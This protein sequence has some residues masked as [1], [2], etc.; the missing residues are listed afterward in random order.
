MKEF[1]SILS[2]EESLLEIEKSKFITHTCPVETENEALNFINEIK[3]RHYNATHNVSAFYIRDNYFYKKYSDDGEPG[4]TAGLPSLQAILNKNV[5]DVC[6]V[7]T[8]YFGGIKL[9][10]GGLVRAYTDATVKGLEAS[11]IVRYELMTRYKLSILYDL[12][13]V[14]QYFLNKNSILV[15]EIVYDEQVHITLLLGED[16]E[17]HLSELVNLT[18]GKIIIAKLE[19]I[20][21]ACEKNKI[22][23]YKSI[24][25]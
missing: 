2:R 16:E 4:G 23:G 12:L 6:V 11:S 14:V 25:E 18:A 22:L 21:A 1:Y 19:K 24:I 7:V 3:K 9:G 5:I 8:R 15:T 20:Y 17:E 10:A 13:N